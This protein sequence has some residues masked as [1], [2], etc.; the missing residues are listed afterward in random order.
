MAT[1]EM[2]SGEQSIVEQ[3]LR[4]FSTLQGGRSIFAGQWEE[5]AEL[6]LPTSRNTFYYG[7][8]NAPGQK[9]TERQVDSNAAVALS[10]FAAILDSL[11]T[12]RNSF[13]HMLSVDNED[14]KKIRAVRLWFEQ[15]TNILFKERYKPT[16][17]FSSQNLNTYTSLGAFGNGSVW[18]DKLRTQEGGT[19]LRY[20]S[21][22]LGE[23]YLRENFQGQIDGFCRPFRLTRHQAIQQFGEENLPDGILSATDQGSLFDF[24][25][26]V[27]PREGYD[28]ERRDNKQMPWASYYICLSGGKCLVSEGGFRTFPAPT[29]RYDQYP[30]EIYG[31]GPAMQV[32]PAIKTLNAEK[33]DFLVQGHRAVAPTFLTTDDGL[34]DFSFRPGALNKG[35]MSADGKPLVNV[36]PTGNIQV[37]LEMMNEEKALINDA[38]LV[39]LFQ[40]LTEKPDMTATQVIELANEKGILL[41]P[42]IG[43]QQSEYLGPLIERELDVL[44]DIGRLPP[45]PREL[46]EAQ[47]EY[48]VVYTSPLAKAMKYQEVAGFGRTMEMITSIVQVTQD[49]SPLDNFD[50]DVI[51]REVSDIQA[52]PESWMADPKVVQAKREQRQKAMEQ[53]QQ[54]QAAP[55]AAALAKVQLDAQ[56]GGA[57]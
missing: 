36:L 45:M 17:N 20:K 22:P 24:L 35:G 50:F 15:V 46:I 29:T 14:L 18:V 51:S 6:V 31:R 8:Y 57:A 11:L 33:H 41:A 12:P 13:W 53:Q 7:S 9:K 30:G 54:I 47:G 37:S 27:C 19:G 43:R 23:M 55:A 1:R 3:S 34:V 42:T 10:R 32:L 21:L 56:K 26:R 52:V 16:A 25:H 5:V 40:I 2:T 44:M 38:F 39:S 48:H 4:E 49:P 28:P